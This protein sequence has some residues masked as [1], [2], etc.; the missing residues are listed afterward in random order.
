MERI[1]DIDYIEQLIRLARRSGV[2]TLTLGQLSF[3]LGP[4][5]VEPVKEEPAPLA[6]DLTQL[7]PQEFDARAYEILKRM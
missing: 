2:A 3:V 5:S 1:F 4:E 6:P 7:T